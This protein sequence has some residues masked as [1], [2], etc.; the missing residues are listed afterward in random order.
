MLKVR[1]IWAD[2]GEVI[3]EWLSSA[4]IATLHEVIT[5]GSHPAIEA[6]EILEYRP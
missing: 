5:S 4:K 3:K 2:G 1:I 6:I